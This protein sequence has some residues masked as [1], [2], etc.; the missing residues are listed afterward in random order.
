MVGGLG[1]SNCRVADIYSDGHKFADTNYF[2]F[3]CLRKPRPCCVPVTSGIHLQ[4]PSLMENQYCQSKHN[5]KYP[6]VSARMQ[7][8]ERPLLL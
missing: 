6:I 1:W 8:P 4:V 5:C 7:T 3:F 2:S